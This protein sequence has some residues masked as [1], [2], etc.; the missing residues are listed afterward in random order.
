M[1]IRTNSK[2]GHIDAAGH[3]TWP[4]NDGC[5]TP[6]VAIVLPPG[7]DHVVENTGPEKLYC[8]TV[9]VPNEGFAEMIRDGETMALD[10]AD[11]A[12]IAG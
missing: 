10:K 7:M 3:V 1:T 12:T 11:T 4:P 5:A 9:M 2:Q 8:L 6:A